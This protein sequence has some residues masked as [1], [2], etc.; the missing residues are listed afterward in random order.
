MI[1]EIFKKEEWTT[2]EEFLQSWEYGEFLKDTG[3][4]LVRYEF[5]S[6]DNVK[7]QF[8]GVI[9]SNILGFKFICRAI[10]HWGV[11][12]VHC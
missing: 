2:K 9:T 12:G 1:K 4:K 3:R 8:Q 6:K 11:S 5:I 10:Q 7:N